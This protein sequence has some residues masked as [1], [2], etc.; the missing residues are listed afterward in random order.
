[1]SKSNLSLLLGILL[2]LLL[3]RLLPPAPAFSPQLGRAT[4]WQ[5]YETSYFASLRSYEA[6]ISDL[7]SRGYIPVVVFGDSTI[8]GTGATG[9]EVWTRVLEKRLQKVEPKIRVVNYAQ[10]AGDILG[11][12][13]FHHL[14]QI[15]PEVR[16]IVQWHFPSE[17]GVRHPFHYWLTSE[18]A[19]RTLGR[20]PAVKRSHS[21]VPPWGTSLRE[22][23]NKGLNVEHYSF[24][25]AG[26]NIVTNYLD[27]GN[28]LRYLIFG[29]VYFD[30]DRKVKIQGLQHIGESDL[31][32]PKFTPR[33]DTEKQWS[34]IL[35]NRIHAQSA[36]LK[37]PL[38]QRTDYFSEIFP[39]S[40]RKNLLL[41]TLD[42]NPYYVM[43]SDQDNLKLWTLNWKTL[44]R[45]MQQIDNLRWVSLSSP[46]DEF[47]INDFMDLGHLTPQGQKR[48]A[49]KVADSLISPGGWF[50][51]KK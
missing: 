40:V 48:I 3:V 10:N 42:L 1:M 18:I 26:L 39:L 50:A 27:A 23:A 34:E 22:F 43:N 41:L 8:R 2:A 31:T 46:L 35:A 15:F 12:F 24:I 20:N 33:A 49:D 25:L 13:L 51:V 6:H 45:D 16:Y 44:R 21:I 17:V 30:S 4:Y 7:L 19:L 29:R 11:P 47:Q 14:Q 37:L 38:R 9:D 32:V 36:Y 5:S 28:W